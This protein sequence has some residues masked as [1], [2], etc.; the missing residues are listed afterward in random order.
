MSMRHMPAA[1][2]AVVTSV[3]VLAAAN[4]AVGGGAAPAWAATQQPA[5]PAAVGVLA[6]PARTASATSI[7]SKVVLP[8]TSID[9]PPF[10]GPA[11]AF[12]GFPQLAWTGTDAAHRLNV[13]RFAMQ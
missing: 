12:I 9:G 4:G 13:A 7:V 10:G 8:E 3:I 5:Y 1:V 2:V 6:A 11:L